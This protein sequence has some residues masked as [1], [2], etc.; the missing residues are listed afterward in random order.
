MSKYLLVGFGAPTS[1]TNTFGF[2]TSTQNTNPFGTTQAKTFGSTAQPLFGTSTNTTPSG[3]GTSLFGQTN[4]QVLIIFL[5]ISTDLL[6]SFIH[7]KHYIF[8]L[9]FIFT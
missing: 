3:F 7:F 9:H 8:A 6:W 4:T 2:G 1:S 5:L